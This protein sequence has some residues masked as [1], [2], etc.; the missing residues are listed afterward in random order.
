MVVVRRSAGPDATDYL[1]LHRAQRGA[2]YEG[3]WAWTPPS[4]ARLPGEAVLAGARRELAEEAGFTEAPLIPVDLSGGWAVFATDVPAGAQAR[5]DPEHDRFEWLTWAD[6]Q[7]RCRP[8]AVEVNFRLGAAVPAPAISFRALA[9]SDLPDI[10][11]WQHEPHAVRW[12]PE[13]LDLAAA[14]RK[15]G[16]RIAGTSPTTVHMLLVDGLRVGFIQH[17]RL[18][19]YPSYQAACGG[20][21]AVGIDY[22]IGAAELTGR[23]LGAQLIWSYLQRV[24]FARWPGV[25]LVAASPEVA[26]RRSIRALAKAGFEVAGEIAGEREDRPELLCVLDRARIFGPALS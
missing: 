1:V 4:G 6:A 2:G 24:V 20:I 22:L 25:P 14:R 5:L 26:N 18:K 11:A 8:E 15:Y 23:G 17:Y 9:A 7:R 16:P 21:D 19:D 3:D 13:D 10:V 12:F